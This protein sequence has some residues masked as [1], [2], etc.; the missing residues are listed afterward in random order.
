[1]L[2]VVFLATKSTGSPLDYA[3]LGLLAAIF[4][5]FY[6]FYV[7]DSLYQGLPIADWS[8]ARFAAKYNS[9]H[10][11]IVLPI[12]FC[13]L[14]YHMTDIRKAKRDG[15]CNKG[16]I[17]IAVGVLLFSVAARAQ[18]GRF[19]VT[20]VPI[21]LY[22]TVL[23]LWGRETARAALFPI[24]FLAFIIPVSGPIDQATSKLQFL[25]V[26]IAQAVCNVIGIHLYQV[27]TT[28]RPVDHSFAGFEIA[29]GC[30]GIR[31]M[32]AMI[33]VTVLY[34]HLTQKKLWKQI[35]IHPFCIVF[36]IIGNS[37]R[38]VSIF[39][40]EKLFGEKFAGGPYHEVSG[41]VSFPIALTAMVGMSWVLDLPIFDLAH[42]I[43]TGEVKPGSKLETLTKKDHATYDY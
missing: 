16:L 32:V 6:Y 19:A 12:F 28:L 31:S 14:W 41:Y 17:W 24:F 39:V 42:S 43:K 18:Q 36:A 30:S 8:W 23:Y 9:E 3:K 22:G 5:T 27:G 10:G 20:A 26:G 38:I 37:G 4:A 15:G 40:V 29:E 33:M 1:M 34:V 21:L 25:V 7:V 35:V 13:M 11:Q 2:A